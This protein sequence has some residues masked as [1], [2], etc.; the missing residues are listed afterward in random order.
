MMT[1]LFGANSNI[2]FEMVAKTGRVLMYDTVVVGSKNTLKI[3]G[4]K[5]GDVIQVRN[6]VW[7]KKEN[8]AT[9]DYEEE[10]QEEKISGE[11]EHDTW[12]AKRRSSS[13]PR[14][15]RKPRQRQA[16]SPRSRDPRQQR[17]RAAAVQ[18]QQ[19]Q[20]EGDTAGSL[21]VGCS[22]RFLVVPRN[23]CCSVFV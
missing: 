5:K 15:R 8:E 21:T 14:P 10:M 18:R 7:Q 19:G 11:D 13:G 20:G 12:G 22:T 16:L 23:V 1:M 2:A 4:M 3:H 9:Q 6:V 17:R